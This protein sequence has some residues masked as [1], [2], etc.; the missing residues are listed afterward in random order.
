MQVSVYISPK[1]GVLDPQGQAA[2]GA[3]KSLGF[4]EV[5]EVRIGKYI[6][7]RLEGADEENVD[8]RVEDMCRKLLANPVIEDHRFEIQG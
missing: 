2:L 1:E 4:E 6:T 3:L 7:L 5:S 8:E